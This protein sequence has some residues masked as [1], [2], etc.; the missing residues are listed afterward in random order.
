LRL[1]PASLPTVMQEVI[2]E[3]QWCSSR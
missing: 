3:T 1:L 2:E